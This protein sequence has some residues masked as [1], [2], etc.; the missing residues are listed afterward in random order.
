MRAEELPSLLAALLGSELGVTLIPSPWL[1]P[2]LPGPGE[3]MLGS[4]LA[5]PGILLA[6]ECWRQ[7]GAEETPRDVPERTHTADHCLSS[8]QEEMRARRGW[9]GLAQQLEPLSASFKASPWHS[10]ILSPRLSPNIPSL[11]AGLSQAHQ[12]QSLHIKPWLSLYTS[13]RRD[14]KKGISSG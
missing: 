13:M 14:H 10:T 4:G 1:S 6:A 7:A 2:V 5:L 8:R 9:H 12:E 11:T 3:Q